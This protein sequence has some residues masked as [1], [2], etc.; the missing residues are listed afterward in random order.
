MHEMVHMHMLTFSTPHGVWCLMGCH[1]SETML[2]YSQAVFRVGDVSFG[3]LTFLTQHVSAGD[4]MW[5]QSVFMCDG[6]GTCICW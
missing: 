4:F 1:A 5:H 6:D 3:K 2:H